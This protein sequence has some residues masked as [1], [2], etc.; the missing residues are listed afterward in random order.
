MLRY[1]AFSATQIAFDNQQGL[2]E[3]CLVQALCSSRHA[4]VFSLSEDIAFG[5]EHVV[6]RYSFAVRGRSKKEK[7]AVYIA[8]NVSNIMVF[9]LSQRISSQYFVRRH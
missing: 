2:P 7:V 8:I 6:L 9:P 1:Y 3:S 5:T 4:M